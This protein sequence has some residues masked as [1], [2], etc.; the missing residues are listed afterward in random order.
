M[1]KTVNISLTVHFTCPETVNPQEAANAVA[2]RCLSDIQAHMH[3]IENGIQ[4]ESAELNDI[5][6]VF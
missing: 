6:V 1:K 4:I 2:E 5:P 3:T